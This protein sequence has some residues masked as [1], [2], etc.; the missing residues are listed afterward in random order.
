MQT[1]IENGVL[2]IRIPMQEPAPSKSGK[3]RIVATTHGSV[4]STATV[5]GQPIIV[6]LNAYIR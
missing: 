3:T 6:S 1:T 5:S 4:Q 2:V